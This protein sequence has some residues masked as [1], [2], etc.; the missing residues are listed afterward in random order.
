MPTAYLSGIEFA[1]KRSEEGKDRMIAPSDTC[2]ID[3]L[4]RDL[5]ELK[6]I[7]LKGYAGG[8]GIKEF[9]EQT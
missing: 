7:Y 4:T 6:A 1:E 3:T 8:S 9:P 5:N 2:R